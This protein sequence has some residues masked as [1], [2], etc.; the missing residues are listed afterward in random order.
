MGRKP[1]EVRLNDRDFQ[2]GDLLHLREWI[3][4]EERYTP[5][6]VAGPITYLTSF[7]CQPGYV[8]LGNPKA[9]QVWW[10]SE[11]EAVVKP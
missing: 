9:S 6:E 5:R 8:V 4:Q 3:P 10:A 2:V 7:G 1:F 11:L